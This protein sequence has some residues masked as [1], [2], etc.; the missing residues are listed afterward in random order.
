MTEK[1]PSKS[2]Y[3]A[4]FQISDRDGGAFDLTGAKLTYVLT[5][6]LGGDTILFEATETQG[7][8]TIE[9]NGEKGVAVITVPAE[10]VPVGVVFEELRVTKDESIVVSQRSLSFKRVSTE[11]Q[12]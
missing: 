7:N 9:P 12:A 2:T 4:R 5:Q 3:R 6:E 10:S 8:T 11:P 1:H